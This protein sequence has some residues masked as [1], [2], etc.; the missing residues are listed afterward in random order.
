[1]KKNKIIKIIYILLMTISLLFI[2]KNA[3]YAREIS[4]PASLNSIYTQDDTTIATIGGR[5]MWVM[6][7]IFYASAVIIL[8]FAGVSYM[9][10]APEG[11]AEI[12]KKMIY[13]A[14]GAI[15]LFAAGGITQIVA[16]LAF[17]N[18]R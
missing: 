3:I 4:V 8:I 9:Y 17:Y 5:I 10:A 6:Q 18:I 1:M 14:I 11:K 15:L 7:I 16:N 2:F 12:K 13:L